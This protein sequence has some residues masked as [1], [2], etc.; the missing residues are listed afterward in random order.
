MVILVGDIPLDERSDDF[1][2]KTCRTLSSILLRSKIHNFELAVRSAMI[3]EFSCDKSW[4]IDEKFDDLNQ[5]LSA[6][7]SFWARIKWNENNN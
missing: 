2:K 3:R 6:V 1:W 4:Q 7:A 5:S